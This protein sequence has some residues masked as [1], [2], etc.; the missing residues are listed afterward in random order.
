[1]AERHERKVNIRTQKEFDSILSPIK[2]AAIAHYDAM[3][4]L[5]TELDHILIEDDDKGSD[6]ARCKT[7]YTDGTK[8][9]YYRSFVNTLNEGQLLFIMAHETAHVFFGHIERLKKNSKN[10]LLMNVATDYVINYILHNTIGHNCTFKHQMPNDLL[11]DEKHAGKDA[12]QIY[13]ELLKSAKTINVSFGGPSGGTCKVDGSGTGEKKITI[14]DDVIQG[15]V[16]NKNESELRQKIANSYVKGEQMSRSMNDK[17]QGNRA[18]GFD[19]FFN[20]FLKPEVRWEE[21]LIK[22]IISKGFSETDWTRCRKKYRSLRVNGKPVFM[23]S[24][25]DRGY[26]NIVVCIDT[27]GSIDQDMINKF[28]SE[29][30]GILESKPNTKV[31]IWTADADVYEI[32]EFTDLYQTKIGLKGGGGTSF[33]PAFKRADHLRQEGQKF[34]TFIYFTDLMGDM[35]SEDLEYVADQ[36]LWVVPAEYKEYAKNVPFGEVIIVRD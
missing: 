14:N 8:C 36:T 15:P 21:Q 6:D 35:P 17:G 3:G 2:W 33:V 20:D 9:Y 29:V 26:G 16:Q 28:I 31:Q 11:Y 7:A 19:R 10:P 13:Y 25:R 24:F 27:S 4:F 32:G 22:S 30:Q 23:P 5:L 18:A 12:E 1:M 34:H